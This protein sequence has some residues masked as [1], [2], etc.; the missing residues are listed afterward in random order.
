MGGSIR[1]G[2]PVRL[3]NLP[4][5]G[6]CL[7][8]ELEGDCRSK[9]SSRFSQVQA[10][11]LGVEEDLDAAIVANYAGCCVSTSESILPSRFPRCL[12][13]QVTLVSPRF[14]SEMVHLVGAFILLERTNM[15]D[16]LHL[17]TVIGTL[18]C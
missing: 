16:D 1:D 5:V 15:S 3:S 13:A 2:E 18:L 11:A 6:P 7:M 12:R 4:Q 9:D 14:P 10:Q 17:N 8:P